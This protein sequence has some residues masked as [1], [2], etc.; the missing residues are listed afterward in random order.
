MSPSTSAVRM[1]LL[2]VLKMAAM[3]A[4]DRLL[5]A[6]WDTHARTSWDGSTPMDRLPKAD[7]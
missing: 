6:V 1:I 2:N 7:P 4:E 5:A 3:G